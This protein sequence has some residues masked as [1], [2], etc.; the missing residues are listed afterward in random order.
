MT[1]DAP[2]P[3]VD[4]LLEAPLVRDRNGES[5]QRQLLHRIRSGILDGRLPS[6]CRLP[7]SQRR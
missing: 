2:G 1:D 4:F 5:L 7:G 6:G 3:L